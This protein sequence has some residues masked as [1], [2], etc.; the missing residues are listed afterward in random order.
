MNFTATCK[1]T[2]NPQSHAG[3]ECFIFEGTPDCVILQR[4]SALLYV[5]DASALRSIFAKVHD[6]VKGKI[7]SS[8]DGN[9]GILIDKTSRSH[10]NGVV[11]RA[12]PSTTMLSWASNPADACGS[13][14]RGC[15][16]RWRRD[17][18]T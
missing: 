9:H 7:P 11:S 13:V 14:Q 5:P 3:G 4:F 18:A 17:G 8:V 6:G 12:L 2:S 16:V 15:G 1:G 10:Y